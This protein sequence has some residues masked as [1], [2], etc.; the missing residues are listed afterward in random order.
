MLAQSNS[1]RAATAR[2][3]RPGGQPDLQLKA[4]NYVMVTG[5]K[6]PESA[7]AALRDLHLQRRYAGEIRRAN[8]FMIA[9]PAPLLEAA[10]AKGRRPAAPRHRTAGRRGRHRRAVALYRSGVPAED[11]TPDMGLFAG[12]DLDH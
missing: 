12:T 2:P 5:N 11:R 3:D 4:I 1:P 10:G 7:E 6:N 9:V 8:G